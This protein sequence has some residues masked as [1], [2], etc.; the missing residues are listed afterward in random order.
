LRG[1][2]GRRELGASR[3]VRRTAESRLPRRLSLKGGLD[4]GR[5]RVL[6]A[7]LV[8]GGAGSAGIAT[9]GAVSGPCGGDLVAVELGQVVAAPG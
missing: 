8:T 2:R 7:A 3:D 6:V 4:R 5:S 1:F 9:A